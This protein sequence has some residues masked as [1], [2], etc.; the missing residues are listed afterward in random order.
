MTIDVRDNAETRA[1][2]F[3]LEVLS[4]PGPTDKLY[5][6]A[7]LDLTFQFRVRDIGTTVAV[8]AEGSLDGREW[9]NL[10][11]GDEDYEITADGVYGMTY[12]G[13]ITYARFNFVSEAGG[14]PTIDVKA[15]I[16]VI[17]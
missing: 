4:T 2:P 13:Y 1:E 15:L 17:S 12:R 9:Y 10:D 14:T 8:R 16:G 5:M 11:A 6:A 7:A 3:D